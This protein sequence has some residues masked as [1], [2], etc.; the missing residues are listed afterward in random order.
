M[1]R[2][3][4][5]KRVGCYH[6]ECIYRK[7]LT[8]SRIKQLEKNIKEIEIFLPARYYHKYNETY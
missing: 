5:E 1:R 4:D 2:E 6:N 3:I 8:E 7:I